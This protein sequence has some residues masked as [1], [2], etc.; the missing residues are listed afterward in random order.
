MLPAAQ[1]ASPDHMNMSSP[2]G[3]TYQFGN[4]VS[5]GQYSY[6]G[7]SGTIT[8]LAASQNQPHATTNVAAT[9][10]GTN[11]QPGNK[12]DFEMGVKNNNS[13]SVKN[14]YVYWH[15][16]YSGDYVG[17][18]QQFGNAGAAYSAT[19]LPDDYQTYYDNGLCCLY[20]DYN[21]AIPYIVQAFHVDGTQLVKPNVYPGTWTTADTTFPAET[22]AIIFGN[23]AI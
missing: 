3:G 16:M 20:S 14:L 21:D 7:I 5:P 10:W 8:L 2:G 4:E 11:S 6:D 19:I 18:W 9:M 22:S 15:M 23:A 13:F 17:S 1:G 12:V